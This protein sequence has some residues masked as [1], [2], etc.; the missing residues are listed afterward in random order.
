MPCVPHAARRAL[1]FLAS[2]IHDPEAMA[3]LK[4]AV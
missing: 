2:V 3:V 1:H 4:L